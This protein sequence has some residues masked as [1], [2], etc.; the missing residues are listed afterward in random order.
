MKRS[1]ITLTFLLVFTFFVTGQSIQPSPF[2]KK[3]HLVNSDELLAGQKNV[4]DFIATAPPTGFVESIAEFERMQGV[5][6]SYPGYFGIPVSSIA[7]MSQDIVVYT[8]V[9][10]SNDQ[11]DVE[12]IY[13]SANVNMSNVVFITAGLN[14]FWSRDYSAWFIREDSKISIV[15]FPYNRPRPDDDEVPVVLANYFGVDYYG[16][17]MEHTGGNYMTDGYGLGASTELV[18]EENSGMSEA[19]IDTM[20]KKYLGLNDYEILSDPLGEYIKH[21]DCWAKFLAPNK[22]L[23]ASVPINDPRYAD[24]EA[25]AGY[26]ASK[27]SAY[28]TPFEV[29]RTYSTNGQPYT[30]S[31]IINDMVFVPQVNGTGSSYNDS[32]LA[33]YHEAMP[34]YRVFGAFEGNGINWQS[35]DAF[36][37]RTHGVADLGMLNIKHIPLYGTLDYQGAGFPVHADIM[38][39]SNSPLYSDS[40]LIWYRTQDDSIWSSSLLVNDSLLSFSGV[41]PA[42]NPGDTIF[43]YL[44]AA[45]QSNRSE[46]HPFIGKADPHWFIN[47]QQLVGIGELIASQNS[48][49]VYPNPSNGIFYIDSE[50]NNVEIFN[51][52]GRRIRSI[53]LSQEM[54]NRID[55][56]D[57]P[58]GIYFIRALN[59]KQLLSQRLIIE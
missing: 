16:M 34:G 3:K 38:N 31:L 53:T 57:L 6:I 37:C 14:S 42:Q 2:L 35:T 47:G 36:H 27:T 9:E 20:A 39:Y 48:L 8:I 17:D 29:Y 23:I 5:V 26:W 43:Y 28:G 33:V 4:N 10:N 7:Q 55:L 21:I 49:K 56:S 22:I 25:M 13:N 58:K 44:H 45:D 32:A 52:Q 19:D 40:L 18:L 54:F 51:L 50:I 1:T 59:E 15:D 30:N 46:N 12:S 11:L 24:F 41:I